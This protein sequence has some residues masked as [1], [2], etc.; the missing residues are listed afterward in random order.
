VRIDFVEIANFRK[1]LSIRVDLSST[2]T[3]FVGANNSGKTSAL[4]AMRRFLSPRRCNFELHDFTLCHWPAVIALGDSWITARNAEKVISL[5]VESWVSVLPTLDLRLHVEAG[6]MHHVRDLI[7]T[8][9]WEGGRLGVRLR[10]EPKD[11]ALLYKD[12]MS[13]VRDAE[14]IKAAA[15][16]AA[17]AEQPDGDR[18]SPKLTIWP[19][20]LI[21]FLGKKLAA[22]FTIRAYTLDPDKLVAPDKSLARPQPLAAGSLPIEGDH[23]NGLIR[24]H[25]IPAQRGFGEEQTSQ[26]EEEAPSAATGSQG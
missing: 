25:D 22:H 23:L 7:P 15:V 26:D 20:S 3:L 13:A 24:V 1:L 2:T 5:D 12:F 18:S 4:L 19:A 21:D 8:L 17:A 9:D 10:Y 16:E 6:E 11:T 14:A